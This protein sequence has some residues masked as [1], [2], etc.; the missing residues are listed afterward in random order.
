MAVGLR[1]YVYEWGR[2]ESVCCSCGNRYLALHEIYAVDGVHLKL[3]GV[4]GERWSISHSCDDPE[5]SFL[6]MYDWKCCALNCADD[7]SLM[8][9]RSSWSII[10]TCSGV[11]VRLSSSLLIHFHG[12]LG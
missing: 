2:N 8:S 1:T 7:P 10:Q 6:F 9:F 12:C 4:P 3:S 11:S 5:L